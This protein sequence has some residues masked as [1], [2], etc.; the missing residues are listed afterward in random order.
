MEFFGIHNC[1]G[2]IGDYVQVM[3]EIWTSW[4]VS[5]DKSVNAWDASNSLF[6]KVST[7][8]NGSDML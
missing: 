4:Q 1:R 8:E 3:F 5:Y 6:Y 7:F 2:C